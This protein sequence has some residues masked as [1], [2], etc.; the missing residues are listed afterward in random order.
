VSRGKVCTMSP[1]LLNFSLTKGLGRRGSPCPVAHTIIY[2]NPDECMTEHS[3]WELDDQFKIRVTL[4]HANH[5]SLSVTTSVF[6][7]NSRIKREY[8]TNWKLRETLTSIVQ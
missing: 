6:T 7:I 1:W 5:K 4:G 8:G 3:R 2:Q